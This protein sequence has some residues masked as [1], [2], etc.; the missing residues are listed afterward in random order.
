MPD[1]LQSMAPRTYDQ[2]GALLAT[3]SEMQGSQVIAQGL[4][5]IEQIIQV[6]YFSYGP[7]AAHGQSYALPHYGEFANAGIKNSFGTMFSLQSC[8]TLVNISN[9]SKVFAKS[10]HF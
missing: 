2:R 7:Q 9:I 1:T 4:Q 8:K 5:T 10:H 3:R 6:L